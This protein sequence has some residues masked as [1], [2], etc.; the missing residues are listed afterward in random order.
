MAQLLDLAPEVLSH[1]FQDVE[2]TDLASLSKTCQYLHK[3]IQ[4]DQL[5]W[6]IHYLFQ[7]DPPPQDDSQSWQDRLS[8]LIN[9]QKILESE[10]EAIK[11]AAVEEVLTQAVTLAHQSTSSSHKTSDFL[12]DLFDKPSNVNTFLCKSS[13]FANA[14]PD[15]WT[16][17]PTQDLRQLSAQLH[18]LGGMNLETSWPSPT[19]ASCPHFAPDVDDSDDDSDEDYQPPSRNPHI[20]GPAMPIRHVHPYARARVYDLRRYTQ[21]NMWGPFMDDG[22]ARVDW[23]KVQAIMI[24]IAY[25]HRMYTERRGL[26]GSSL[27]GSTTTGTGAA[28][29]ATPATPTSFSARSPTRPSHSPTSVLRPWDDP[30]SGI[31]PGSFVSYPLSGALKPSLRPDLD[32]LDPYGVS[33]T[34]MRIVCFLDYNDLYA[35]NF[36]SGVIP[37]NEERPPITTREAFRLIRLQLRVSAVEEPGPD[38]GQDFPVVHFEGAS[39]STFMAWDPNANSRIRGIVRQ[40]PSGAIRWTTFSIFHGEERWRSEGVQIGGLKS[41]RGILGNWFDKDYDVHGPAGP[42]AF[43]KISDEIVEEK[44]TLPQMVQILMAEVNG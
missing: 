34:W 35:F 3:L 43:W 12:A 23:E 1:I 41:A 29:P 9:V 36:E 2:T 4:N 28:T 13:L 19:G 15:A 22:S 30:F 20:P 31:A 39:R 38:D 16:S 7:F 32:A 40:T 33:G 8:R 44:R 42:T 18:V 24:D 26:N 5:L 14:R 6:K 25:N 37:R 21:A 27:L 10:D 11:A 17:A